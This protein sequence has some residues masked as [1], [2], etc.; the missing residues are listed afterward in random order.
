MCYDPRG[1]GKGRGDAYSVTEVKGGLLVVGRARV[2]VGDTHVAEG[3]AVDDAAAVVGDVVEHKP[4]A[5]VEAGAE[6]PLLPVDDGAA[7]A[8]RLLCHHERRAL[9]L[10]HVQRLQV[11]TQLL[12]LGR[13]LVRRRH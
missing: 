3:D 12:V 7:R 8:D 6:P 2:G 5:G 1:T 10:H 13:V 4:L 11:G 9:G